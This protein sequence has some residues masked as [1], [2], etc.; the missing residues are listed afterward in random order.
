VTE[1]GDG[2]GMTVEWSGDVEV[3]EGSRRKTK[4]RVLNSNTNSPTLNSKRPEMG[5]NYS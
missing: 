3:M 5:S 4:V 1:N 2:E